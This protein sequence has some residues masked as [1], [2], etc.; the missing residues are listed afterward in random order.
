MPNG[1]YPLHMVLRP[2]SGS[3][4]LIH[5]QGPEVRI[6]SQGEWERGADKCVPL[7]QL[8]ASETQHLVR[9]LTHWLEERPPSW[10]PV[11]ATYDY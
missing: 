1:G 7:V 3:D 9:F 11:D 10:V 6:Y 8:Q 2:V 4:Y 5:C